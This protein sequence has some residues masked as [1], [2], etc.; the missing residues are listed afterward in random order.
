MN[1]FSYFILF[2]LFYFIH[3]ILFFNV[4]FISF[5]KQFKMKVK[6]N[7]N[8]LC[9]MKLISKRSQLKANEI[10]TNWNIF[11]GGLKLP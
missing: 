6:G 4:Y 8:L 3:F 11:D 1:G 10:K 2:I 5:S 9:Y 7:Q